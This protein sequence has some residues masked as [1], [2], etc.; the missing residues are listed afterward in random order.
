MQLL[1]AL[2]YKSFKYLSLISRAKQDLALRYNYHFRG[3]NELSENYEALNIVY[4]STYFQP[5]AA[6]FDNSFAFNGPSIVERC[7][8][9]DLPWNRFATQRLIYIS[10][11]TIFGQTSKTY[12]MFFETFRNRDF[13]VI[14]SV[15]KGTELISLGDIP[16]N[17]TVR[18]HVPQLEVLKRTSVFIT[19]GGMNSASEGLYFGVPLIVIHQGLDQPLVA[20][21]VEKLGAGIYLRKNRLSPKTLTTA[22]NLVTKDARFR[23]NARLIADS[24][25]SAGGLA[26]AVDEITR[27]LAGDISR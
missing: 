24:F 9:S 23:D 1:P 2:S 26:K 16:A 5:A 15:G 22:I 10:L 17:F 7:D 6:S 4:T 3:F 19:H 27:L 12:R 20:R 18:K 13:H 14:L 8:D 25:K 11:G 21:Q